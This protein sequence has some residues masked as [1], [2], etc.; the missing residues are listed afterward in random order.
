M[1][2]KHGFIHLC[3]DLTQTKNTIN[4]FYR[5]ESVKILQL[6]NDKLFNLKFEQNKPNGEFYPHL[7]SQ[8]SINDIH[9]THTI[10]FNENDI[11]EYYR[12]LSMLFD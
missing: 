2:K 5:F 10:H 12:T 7:Y 9:S 6:N 1:D 3:K 4:K 11:N 8:L